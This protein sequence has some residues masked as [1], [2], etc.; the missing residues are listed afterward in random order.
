MRLHDDLLRQDNYFRSLCMT[1]LLRLQNMVK[2]NH[3]GTI[4]IIGEVVTGIETDLNRR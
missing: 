1:K 3:E 2:A 4:E